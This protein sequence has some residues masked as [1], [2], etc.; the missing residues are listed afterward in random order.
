M[1]TILDLIVNII[2]EDLIWPFNERNNLH[3]DNEEGRDSKELRKEWGNLLM[4]QFG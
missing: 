3:F 4:P 2:G 1:A